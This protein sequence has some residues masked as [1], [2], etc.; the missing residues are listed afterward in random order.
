MAGNY[1]NCGWAH[2]GAPG[3][4]TQILRYASRLLHGSACGLDDTVMFPATMPISSDNHRLKGGVRAQ[5]GVCKKR[6]EGCY[7]VFNNTNRRSQCRKDY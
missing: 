7:Q 5:E 6:I 3:V 4:Y 1:A 2:S